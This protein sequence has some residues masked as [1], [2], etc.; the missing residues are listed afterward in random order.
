MHLR[1]G[2]KFQNKLN[3]RKLDR[4]PA[5]AKRIW[6]DTGCVDFEVNIHELTAYIFTINKAR[7]TFHVVVDL[8]RAV[9]DN[10]ILLTSAN[11]QFK[12]LMIKLSVNEASIW[13]VCIFLI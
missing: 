3:G 10:L 8:L 12:I 9:Y 5:F 7:I 1:L 13:L 4:L 2:Q 11:Y 6:A